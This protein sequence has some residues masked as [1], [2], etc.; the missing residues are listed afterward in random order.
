M[1]YWSTFFFLLSFFLYSHTSLAFQEPLPPYQF[2]IPELNDLRLIA[3]L[4]VNDGLIDEALEAFQ[5]LQKK[6]WEYKLDS[7]AIDVY[8][9]IFTAIIVHEELDFNKKKAFIDSCYQEE[10][11]VNIL[12]VYYGALAHTYLFHGEVDS[13]EKY[14]NLALPIYSKQKRYL[15][16]TNLNVNIAIEYFYLEDFVI[17]KKYLNKAEE[18]S[19]N[20]LLP[21][22][23]YT[24]A[25]YSIQTPLYIELEKYD[26]AV[27]SS[28]AL[29]KY[30]EQSN[31]T[32]NYTLAHE[33]ANL[34]NVY[35]KL[36]D[37]ENALNYYQKALYLLRKVGIH[38][39]DEI[40]YILLDIGAVYFE[41]NKF[42]VAK[43]YFLQTIKLIKQA[44]VLN[45]DLQEDFINACHR[46][47]NCYKIE[48]K[49]DSILYYC[50]QAL[51][52]NKT[53][54]YR[55]N[56][57]YIEYSRYYLKQHNLAKAEVYAFK[58]LEAANKIY[59]VEHLATTHNYTFLG[60]ILFAKRNYT[61][62]FEYLQKSLDLLSV[63]F[64]DNKGL[65]NPSLEQVIEKNQ[66]LHTLNH[67]M[68]YLNI[69]YNQNYP[70][71]T[72][73]ILYQ[74]AKLATETIEA[75]NTDIKSRKSQLFWLNEEAIP[76][77]ERAITIAL[78]IYKRTDNLEYLN[79]AFVL[80][81][82]S[83]SML[84]VNNFQGN[85][86]FN[87]GGLPPDLVKKEQ[88]LEKLLAETKKQRFD[89]N[90]RKDLDAIEYLDSVIFEYKHDKMTLLHTFELEYP[91]YSKLKHV[92]KSVDIRD[93]QN[94]LDAQTTFIEYFEGAANIYA[95][96]ITKNSASVQIIPRTDSYRQDIL[97]FQALLIGLDEAA[98]N[99]AKS[100]NALIATAHQF[101]Q[102]FIEQSLSQ[103][104]ERLII[105]PDGQL[106]YL[107]FEVFMTKGVA[108][109]SNQSN[110]SANFSNLPYLI[111][112]Y[113]I[114]YNYSA[115]LWIEHL[116]QKSTSKNGRILAFAPSYKN[117]SAPEWRSPY[118][119]KLRQELVELPGAIREL[120]FL[121]REFTGSFLVND[122]ATET[123]FKNEVLDYSI[124]H[125]AV[126]GLVDTKNPE[127]SGLALSED[128]GKTEDNILYTYEIKQLGLNADLVVLSACETG[129]GRYQMGEGILSIGRDFM[130]AGV[131]SML[132]TLWSLNDYSSSII[133]EQFYINLG[134]GMD[135]DEAIQ[136]AKL[137]YL[138]HY[139]GLS[140]HPALWAC[141]VQVG[142]YKSI[143]IHKNRMFWY[144]G[145]TIT[146][147]L[148]LIIFLFF[149]FRKK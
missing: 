102:T 130:Y 79:E 133:I 80:A 8:E 83:K 63:N 69:L 21:R 60:Q 88:E 76:S 124:L 23:L 71:A 67:K 58:A 125:F 138:D 128:G 143:P 52:L 139:N 107:P 28:L 132:T 149:R 106:S 32:T 49:S 145:L 48:Q 134:A 90:L 50:N 95:F 54:S 30:D 4:K 47:I 146:I 135:K 113:K 122:A 84:M 13:M 5:N 20:Q 15:Q 9:D 103:K 10:K 42:S 18:L 53:N 96:S 56:T 64:S 73:K 126:H 116:M 105:I 6:C 136:Q 33:Y 109:D 123:A 140:T 51:K 104:Q 142:D 98:E 147:L 141:F 137:F 36:N 144:I 40:T 129:I 29:I 22:K 46:L 24:P 66:F 65:S 85:Q 119:K 77:F 89:A 12:G 19:K 118:E 61:G 108:I 17:A 81:E 38:D 2:S 45:S 27:K 87:F 59:G 11:D 39:P 25:I 101:Y 82:R 74:T 41:N 68:K 92:F 43:K 99:T 37:D 93:V 148:A 14:Y 34:A 121:K 26:K 7:V 16:A 62:A 91:A 117:K 57:T 127:F 110:S 72:E 70:L 97:D 100:Y 120:D 112:D 75:I 55:I 35:I 44:D 94:T 131:P 1:S 31:G 3:E 115:T 86:A 78:S 111:R 114:N